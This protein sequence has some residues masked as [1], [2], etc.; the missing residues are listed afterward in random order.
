MSPY[1]PIPSDFTPEG[2]ADPEGDVIFSLDTENTPTNGQ[3]HLLKVSSQIMSRASPVF[4]A[5]FNP[6][7]TG[8][9]NFSYHDPLEI[10]LPQDDYQA[11]TWIC[12]ALHLQD[13]PEGR[14]PLELLK[15][16]GILADKYGCAQKLQPW[17]RLWL[18]EWSDSAAQD[19]NRWEFLWMGYALLDVQIF[20]K[21]SERLIYGRPIENHDFDSDS[22]D[23]VGFSLL[24][25]RTIGML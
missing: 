2:H 14:M 24:P 6:R 23:G 3:H 12:F 21:A 11:L 18:D 19:W 16:I 9:A 7:F 1:K 10:A 8:R 22:L 5:M 13:L 4:E 25:A 17:S 15:R 20:Y